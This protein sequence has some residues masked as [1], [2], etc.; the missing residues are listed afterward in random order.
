MSTTLF[1]LRIRLD[2]SLSVKSKLIKSTKILRVD[3]SNH[4]LD[5]AL[6]N[7]FHEKMYTNRIP[8]GIESVDIKYTHIIDNDIDLLLVTNHTTV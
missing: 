1:Y 5:D 7:L 6:F 4:S 3:H 2:S 8:L